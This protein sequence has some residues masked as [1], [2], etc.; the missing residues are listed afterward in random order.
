MLRHIHMYTHICTCRS[1]DTCMHAIACTHMY[2]IYIYTYVYICTHAFKST[3]PPADG[4]GHW[5]WK[6]AELRLCRLWSADLWK[7]WSAP[8]DASGK[9]CWLRSPPTGSKSWRLSMPRPRPLST[10]WSKMLWLLL[11][12]SNVQW[13]GIHWKRPGLRNPTYQVPAQRW[14]N[15]PVWSGHLFSLQQELRGPRNLLRVNNTTALRLWY[16]EGALC[17][18][19]LLKSQESMNSYLLWLCCICFINE[20]C[21]TIIIHSHLHIQFHFFVFVLSTL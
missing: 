12:T 17:R 14:C 20:T 16:F 2:N 5:R 18:T 6:M 9:Y 4:I 10:I 1:T 15:W 11:S 8:T 21:I 19:G 3:L 7:H 13:V